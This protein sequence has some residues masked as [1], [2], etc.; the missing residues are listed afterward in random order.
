M[1]MLP[2]NWNE[3]TPSEKLDFRLDAWATTDGKEFTTPEAAAAF[4]RRTKR[5]VDVLKLR[6]PDR[7]PRLLTAG[8]YVAEYAGV[9]H[10]DVMYDYPKAIEAAAQFHDD[11]D[12]DYQAP[13]SMW[14]GRLFDRLDFQSYQWPGGQLAASRPFQ[15]VEGEYMTADQ[16][17]DLLASP[18]GFMLRHYLP[19]VLPAL[20]GLGLFPSALGAI[21]LPFLP[22]MMLPMGAPPMREALQALL[23]AG[24]LAAEWMGAAATAGGAAE[25]KHGLPRFLGGFT[26]VPF[27]FMGDT[28]RGTKGIM[29]DMYR[30]PEKLLAA[31]EAIT[32][33]AVKMAV[34][35]ANASGNPFIFVVLHKGADGF[36][37]TPD[38]EKFYWPFFKALLE[39]MI[40]EGVVPFNFV[41]GAYNNRLATIA[42]DP[43]PPGTTMWMFD[44]TDMAEAKKTIGQ[45][46]AIGGNVPASLFKAGTPDKMEAYVRN[47]VDVCAPGGGFFLT[48]GAV[49][50]NAEVANVEAYLSTGRQYG[51]Y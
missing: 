42:A 6:E 31:C 4:E 27:D 19:R 45:W 35:G 22:F 23:D 40:A 33:L 11:F 8:G 14:P 26:K 7:V 34:D 5:F 12:L 48:P 1:T 43:L 10:G 47:L 50:D 2:D 28:M 36:M 18:E 15:A 51:Q 46:G 13:G 16:Y 49:V 41:E 3:M 37:S 9:S 39:G 25:A 29:L 38:F 32:P 44:Q 24:D 21:E 17:D 30:R 20:G